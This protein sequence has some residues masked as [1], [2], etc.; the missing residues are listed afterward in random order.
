[1][2]YPAV[3]HSHFSTVISNEFFSGWAAIN[4]CID[5]SLGKLIACESP[6]GEG[7]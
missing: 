7:L 3:W 1:M 5:A 4:G 2:R 6:G